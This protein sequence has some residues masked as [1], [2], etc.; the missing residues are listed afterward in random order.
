M[1]C[2]RPLLLRRMRINRVSYRR[3]MKNVPLPSSA[4]MQT[5][6]N[7][8]KFAYPSPL[9]FHWRSKVSQASTIGLAQG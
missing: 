9:P 5:L 1:L 3:R 4:G 8:A 6:P 7:W 2:Q